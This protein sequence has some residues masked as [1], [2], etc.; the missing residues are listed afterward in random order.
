[1]EGI[2]VFSLYLII[3][4]NFSSK[5]ALTDPNGRMY[6]FKEAE[7]LH[8]PASAPHEMPG[9]PQH[10]F[11]TPYYSPVGVSLAD[12]NND[13]YLEIIVGSTDRRVYIWDFHGNLLDGWPV[14]LPAMIQSKVA[15]GDIDNDGDKEI[16]IAADNGYVYI[17]NHDGTPYPN[18]PQD[19]D[20]TMA[21]ISP[22][23]F[24]LD[25]DGDLEIIMAQSHTG[26]PGH[27]YIWHHTGQLYDGWPQSTDYLAVA[28]VAVADIDND[29]IFEIVCLADTSIYVWDQYGNIKPGWPKS[30]I[31]GEMR[32]AQPVLADLD[33]D[34]DLEILYSYYT[35]GH[36][37]VGIY[38][39]DGSNFLN[40]PQI[41]PGLQTFVMPV[42]GDI[43]GDEDLE[44]FGGGHIA[45][46]PSLS[47]R[48]IDGT[49]V[50]G[51]PVICD[52]LECSPVVSDIDDDGMREILIA[53]NSVPGH[54][55]AYEGDGTLVPDW[56]ISTTSAAMVNSPAIG[57]VDCDGDIEIALVVADGTVNLWTLD[58]VPYHGYY[59]DWGTFHH[60]QWNTGWFHPRPPQDLVAQTYNGYVQLFWHKNNE[61]DIAGYNLYR[62]ETSGGPYEKVNDT[63]IVD[64]TYIDSSIT[65]GVTYYYRVT[66]QIKAFAESR[67]SNEA[68]VQVG[69]HEHQGG[70]GAEAKVP[71][72]FINRI[73]ISGKGLIRIRVFD[74]KGRL[75]KNLSGSGHIK[76]IPDNKLPG[77]VYFIKIE[78]SGRKYWS[79]LLM[80][81]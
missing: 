57:D 60:D 10:V 15:V 45:G 40:W 29:G 54:F 69:I 2:G 34:G 3:L 66:A 14:T 47:A 39:H 17:Y 43:D 9:W 51:W 79:K 28:S 78:E 58:S 70:N 56:P 65:Q 35:G 71:Q 13:G 76:W 48:H 80:V 67:L 5:F 41:Y 49:Q 8:I 44:I 31:S 26:L 19:A 68:S 36:D 73:I 75:V 11:I 7:T 4:F 64:T 23:L 6:S 63:L 16:V 72:L 37:Y 62:S 74:C 46:A 32:L 77:G 33:N 30:N 61:P 50:N 52:M 20:G 81:R 21:I 1:M 55:Y 22:V 24:D 38:H 42:V 59:T 18:W 25:G 53:D 12:V 27:V